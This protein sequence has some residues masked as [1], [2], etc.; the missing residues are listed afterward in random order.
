[1][2]KFEAHIT[3][4]RE[5]SDWVQAAAMENWKFSAI[6]GDALMGKKPY[7]YLTAYDSSAIELFK[8]MTQMCKIL[9]RV[10]VDV[11]RKKVEKI[12]YDTKTNVDE[13]HLRQ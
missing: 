6:D 2:E 9:E 7:C 12:I 3:L 5:K 13:I 10:G 4:P 11:L 1:M 8:S